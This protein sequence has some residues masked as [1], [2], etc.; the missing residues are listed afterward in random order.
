VSTAIDSTCSAEVLMTSQPRVY[1]VILNWNGWQDTIECL[2]SVSRLNYANY[3]VIVCD[4]GSTNGSLDRITSWANGEVLAECANPE[5]QHLTVPH[6]AK[7][8]PFLRL[9]PTDKISTTRRNEKLL[10]V[11]AGSNLGFAGGSNVGLRLALGAGDMDYAWLLNNDTVVDPDSL[12]AMIE[13]MRQFP[14]AGMCGSTLLYYH[15]PRTVQ[16]LGGSSYWRWTARVREIGGRLDRERVPVCEQVERELGYV[17]GASML[18]CRDLLREIGLLDEQYFIYFE[19]IDWATRS[20]GR[21]RLA[22]SPKSFVYHKDG[23]SSGTVSKIARCGC[24]AFFRDRWASPLSEFYTARNRVLFTYKHH[25]L[26]L[27]TVIA[28]IGASGVQRLL[29]GRVQSFRALARGL[30]RGLLTAL[31]PR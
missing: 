22:Y 9:E 2:E 17:S 28:A 26:A 25:V 20:K 12:T 1:V 27:P 15:Q 13:R 16:A 6:V 31:T 8:L 30:F 4:N 19:E 5:L 21:F 23:G 10:L 14:Q 29:Y 11:Q 18:V 3:C 7:P 24:R